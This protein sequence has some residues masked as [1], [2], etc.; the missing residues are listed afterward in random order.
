MGAICLF[1]YERFLEKLNEIDGVT[2][3]NLNWQD[4]GFYRESQPTLSFVIGFFLL[5]LPFVI[6]G[7]FGLPSLSELP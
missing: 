6:L 7:F 5:M 2:E 4:F 3:T 1:L